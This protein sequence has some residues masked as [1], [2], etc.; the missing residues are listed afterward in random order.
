MDALLRRRQIMMAVGSPTPPTPPGP[1]GLVFY[2]YLFFDGT[3]YIDTDFT[4]PANA[5]F[6]CPMGRETLKVAQR[7]FVT[8]AANSAIIGAYISSSTTSSDRYWGMYYGSSSAAST[9]K[10]LSFTYQTYTFFLTPKGFG[11]GNVFNSLTKGSNAPSGPLVLG[12]SYSHTGQPYTGVMGTFEVYG[13]DAQNVQD[14]SGFNSYTPVATFR[15]CTY[16]GVPGMWHVETSTFC[17]NTAGAGKLGPTGYF[18]NKKISIIGDSISTYDE[19]GYKY[20]SYTMYYP[21][22]TVDAVNKTWWKQFLDGTN[23]SLAVNLSYSGS[24]VATRSGYPSLCDRTSLI[25]NCDVVIIALGTNDSAQ[26][27]PIGDYSYDKTIA[28][29]DETYFREAYIKGIKQIQENSPGVEIICAIFSMNADYRNSIIEIA[30]HYNL[31]CIDCGNNYAKGQGVHPSYIGMC[32][33]ARP[34]ELI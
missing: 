27:L 28:Q 12:Q 16:N 3:A 11:Y 4:P 23:A 10:K 15:P 17:G 32:E 1:S 26:S 8:P 20:D 33:I 14:S 13:S 19:E 9:G 21:R 22:D 29:L 2:D 25:G 6:R 34:F 5:S 7:M 24:T 31:K 30:S 18:Y